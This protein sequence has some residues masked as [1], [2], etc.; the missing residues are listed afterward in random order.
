MLF[1][2]VWFVGFIFL[3]SKHY[4]PYLQWKVISLDQSWANMIKLFSKKSVDK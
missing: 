4:I 1:V 2:Q 3:L